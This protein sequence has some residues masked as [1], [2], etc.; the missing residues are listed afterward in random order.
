MKAH[1]HYLSIGP[2]ALQPSSVTVFRPMQLWPSDEGG[3]GVGWSIVL[4]LDH[5]MG[6]VTIGDLG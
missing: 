1:V 2:G 4:V 6:D 3:L 5:G